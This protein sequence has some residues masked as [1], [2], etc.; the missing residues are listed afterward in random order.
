MQTPSNG[1][2]GRDREL[3]EAVVPLTSVAR[4]RRAPA[5]TFPKVSFPGR[6]H[7]ATVRPA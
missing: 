3:D 1:L 2:F 6:P 5:G 4:S 7:V